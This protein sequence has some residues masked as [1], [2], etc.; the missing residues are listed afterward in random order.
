MIGTTAAGLGILEPSSAGAEMDK[1]A[2]ALN[3]FSLYG[4]VQIVDSFPD[5]KV[6]VVDSFPDLNVQ[7]VKNFPDKCGQWKLVTG[8]PD[9]K[10]QYVD[11]FP[12]LKIKFVASF[13]GWPWAPAPSS[14]GVN[15]FLSPICRG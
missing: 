10:I 15:A 14:I 6:Q 4:E 2:C 8:F 12:D 7:I 1:E 11:S 5:L 3:G 13:P 9:V